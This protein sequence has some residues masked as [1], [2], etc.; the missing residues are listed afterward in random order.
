M[1]PWQTPCAWSSR[2]LTANLRRSLTTGPCPERRAW[3]NSSAGATSWRCC[4]GSNLR[5]WMSWLRMRLPS[6]TLLRL[7]RQ[8]DGLRRGLNGPSAHGSATMCQIMLLSC[9]D[10]HVSHACHMHKPGTDARIW[11]CGVWWAARIGAA[12]I[13][14]IVWCI[15]L[16]NSSGLCRLRWRRGY[17]GQEAVVHV[18]VHELPGGHRSRVRWGHHGAAAQCCIVQLHR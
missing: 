4:R 18:H 9:C 14:D 3:S 10:M 16:S 7:L 2:P 8:Q 5:H 17:M 1:T 12:H 11:T 6:L 13:C 15:C